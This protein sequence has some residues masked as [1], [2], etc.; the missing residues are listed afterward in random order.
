MTPERFRQVEELYHAA[1]GAT[2]GERAALLAQTDP[3]L[4]REVESLLVERIGGD[5]LDRPAIENA[6][7]LQEDSTVAELPGGAILGPYRIECKLGE[8]GMG[9][10][11]RALD[12]RLGRSVAIK[13]SHEE[14]SSRFEREARAI[15]SLNH[16]N[17]CTLHDIGPNYLVMELIEGETLAARLKQGSIPVELV[18][19]YGGQIAAAL[20]EA[21]GKGIVHRD[22]KPGNIMIAKSGVKVLD[23]GLATSDQDSTLTANRLVIGTPAY[24]SPEQREG[25]PADARSDI[26][27]FGCVL[28]EMLTRARASSVRKRIPSARLERIV[29]RCLEENPAHRWQSAAELERELTNVSATGSRGGE[30]V[31]AAAAMP[32]LSVGWL[33]AGL[34]LVITAIAGGVYLYSTRKSAVP[35]ATQVEW[36][37]LTDF[38][39]SV[40]SPAISPDGRMLAFIRGTDTFAGQGQVYVK[41]LPNGEPVPLT[42]DDPEKMSPEF[43]LDGSRIAYTAFT[44]TAWDTWAVPVLGGESRLMLANAEGLTW[45]DQKNILF[46]EIKTGVHMALVTAGENRENSREIYVPPRERGMAHR[47]AISPDHKWVL[48]TE[49]DNGGWLPCRLVPFDGS[50][51]GH[52]IGPVSGGCTYVAWSPD[53]AWM[54]FSSDAGGRFHIW[55]QKFSN[56]PPQQVTSGATEEEGIAVAPDGRSLITS[57]GQVQSTIMLRDAKGERQ[58]S[59][60]QYAESPQF[61]H[62]GRYLF[63]VV[64]AHGAAGHQ[65]IK[66]EFSRVDGDLFRVNL[67]TGANEHLLPGF[68][69]RGYALSPDGKRVVF[70]AV[71]PQS[72]VRLWIADL[73][74][75]SSPRQFPSLVDEDDPNFDQNGNI[76]FRAAEGT[77]NFLYRMKEDGSDRVKALPNSILG[78]LGI[79]PDG[80]WAILFQASSKGGASAE[81][82]AAPLSGAT[83]VTICHA[84]C[85]A[86]WGDEGKVLAIQTVAEGADRTVL[87]SVA[88]SGGIPTLPPEGI[89]PDHSSQLATMKG[90][91]IMDKFII[92]APTSAQYAWVSVSIHRNLYSIPLR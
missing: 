33:Y 21:H 34:V 3:E 70:S 10:V 56:G 41:F 40:V 7:Q 55:R 68:P 52:A 39:D 79:S 17:I 89:N 53:G 37:P 44:G 16:P 74:L 73:D 32:S 85:Y 84:V 1:R 54:Y 22:L 91:R 27:S 26:Y 76:Y 4:R 14:F 63:Y 90:A 50:S 38:A 75:R 87:L 82:V 30:R 81:T 49:M 42:H 11:F 9:Q 92:P 20:A 88:P 45:I 12:T 36:T 5:F 86:M 48:L 19:R 13:I 35:V 60:A 77:S 72:R 78:P 46:S 62:D 15:S 57:V 47:S 25:K 66:G 83:P 67:E 51:A 24:M 28:Y 43:S 6:R 23:F 71:D 65:Y 69:I 61:S 18:S 29:S 64:P 59:S 31:L 8:G 80:R 58:V 2:A